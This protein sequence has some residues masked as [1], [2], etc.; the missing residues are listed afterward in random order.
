M[1]DPKITHPSVPI[2][3]P[4]FEYRPAAVTDITLTWR[5]F[6]WVPHNERVAAHAGTSSK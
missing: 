6:G 5:R 3:D 2:T 4:K 1:N